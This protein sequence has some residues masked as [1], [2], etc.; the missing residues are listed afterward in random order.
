MASTQRVR[1]GLVEAP[2]E[3]VQRTSS[4]CNVKPV[5]TTQHVVDGGAFTGLYIFRVFKG[6]IL[7]LR[8]PLTVFPVHLDACLPFGA[9]SHTI[10]AAFRPLCSIPGLSSSMLCVPAQSLSNK[11]T[12]QWADFPSLI[13]LQT[14]TIEQLLDESTSG[15]SLALQMKKAEIATTDLVIL[16]GVSK[17]TSREALTDALRT[18]V[19]DARLTGRSLNKLNAKVS[20]AV[21]GIMAVNDYALHAIEAAEENFALALWNRLIPWNRPKADVILNTFEDSMNYLSFTLQRLVVEFEIN[22]HNLN[23]LE[24]QLSVLHEIVT[25]KDIFFSAAKTKLLSNLWTVLGGNRKQLRGYQNHL[26]LLEGLGNYRKQALVHVISAL[27]TLTQ[28]SDDIENLRERVAAP[29]LTGSRI[30]AH[31]HIKSIHSGLERIK[32][33]RTKAKEKEVHAVRRIVGGSTD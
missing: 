9:M 22:L 7:L 3:R 16:V 17:L 12:P 24:E 15:S 29:G 11:G 20:G 5:V 13:S 30:P 25:R 31:V 6:A 8:I 14:S 32:E 2:Y 1:D 23:K 33:G 21:D 27:Q 26:K 10:Q 19:D 4:L 18:F 28:M